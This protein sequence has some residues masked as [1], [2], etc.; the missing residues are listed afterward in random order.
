[1][2]PLPKLTRV[3]ALVF[4]SLLVGC[5]SPIDPAAEQ[6]FLDG[7]A[8][9]S[10]TVY[11]AVVRDGAESS[12]DVAGATELADFLAAEFVAEAKVS[13]EEVAV[14]G[15]W[16]SNEALMWQ[17]SAAALAAHVEA[18]PID[19]AY[20]ILPEYLILGNGPVGGIHCYVVDAE[21]TLAYGLL[22]NSHHEE[23]QDA[24]PQTVQ[25]CTPVLMTALRN[26][27]KAD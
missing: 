4:M 18:H 27:L 12:Y 6:K 16:H 20:A 1:M 25:D 21:G 15:G 3:G 11:P 23:F 22:L 14:T 13:P 24:D 5:Q 19:T 7:L 2:Y 17:E 9:T 10:I 26:E 8:S